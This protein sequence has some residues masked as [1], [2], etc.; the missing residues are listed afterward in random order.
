MSD[1]TGETLVALMKASCAQFKTATPLEHLHAL[2][3][4][5]DQMA[6]T[7]EDIRHKPG[8]VLYTVANPERR[9]MLEN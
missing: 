6:R 5:E 9:K 1:S 4:S 2:V 8:V 3:R 7:L